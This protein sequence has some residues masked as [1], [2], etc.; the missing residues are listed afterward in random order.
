M[1]YLDTHRHDDDLADIDLSMF[2]EVQLKSR[3][4]GFFGEDLWSRP[5]LVATVPRGAIA[6]P[7]V[8]RRLLVHV[9]HE[10]DLETVKRT[11]VALGLPPDGAHPLVDG[12]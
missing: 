8:K 6:Q 2:D 11:R 10:R 7:V 3:H 1:P 9:D 5:N 4:G 12:R